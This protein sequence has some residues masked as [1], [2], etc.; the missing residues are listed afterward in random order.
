MKMMKKKT[1]K[2]MMKQQKKDDSLTDKP[3]PKEPVE[4]P[5]AKEEEESEITE[6][7]DLPSHHAMIPVN[8]HKSTP[9]FRLVSSQSSLQKKGEDDDHSK[10]QWRSKSFFPDPSMLVNLI[11]MSCHPSNDS[12]LLK[13]YIPQFRLYLY[14]FSY[15]L[16][17][18][19]R[20]LPALTSI[21]STSEEGL[22]NWYMPS[23]HVNDPPL[24]LWSTQNKTSVLR[25]YWNDNK[26][27]KSIV[28]MP[29]SF[30]PNDKENR[31]IIRSKPYN[32]FNECRTTNPS[33]I[34]SILLKILNKILDLNQNSVKPIK[35]K[36][37]SISTDSPPLSSKE[38]E[39]NSYEYSILPSKSNH[40]TVKFNSCE[41]KLTSFELAFF[42]FT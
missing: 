10:S 2:K 35:S 25:P 29:F 15:Q 39:N 9:N 28:T 5:Q 20:K 24:E 8:S 36:T 7:E 16:M 37:K 13:Y 34:L 23:S 40:T 27:L 38:E 42:I 1:K 17:E 18:R 12:S 33:S 31:L 3:E 22:G 4:D 6:T 30:N 41:L 26:H 21:S 32:I 19:L 14:L 11:W